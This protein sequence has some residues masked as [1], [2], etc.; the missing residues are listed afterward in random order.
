MRIAN[1]NVNSVRTRVTHMVQFLERQN[2]DVLLVQETKCKD[3]Q[4]PYDAFPD[5]EIAHV[6]YSQWNGVAILSRVGLDDVD[7]Q[8]PQQPGFH[9][10]PTQPQTVEARAV[11]ATC[12]GVRVWSVYV[13]N[14]R[15]IADPHYDY[16]L[17]WLRALSQHVQ[18][19]EGP[20]VIGGDFNIAPEDTHVWDRAAFTGLTHV[21]EPERQAFEHLLDAGL[22]VASPQD[23]YSYWDYKGYRI[24]RNEGMLIDF[25]LARDL[26]VVHSFIDVEE[27]H[28]V[29]PS[30][31]APVIV[32]YT[33]CT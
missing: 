2:I 10:D 33:P 9:K 5:Y 11:G 3:A 27:R 16:K 18:H 25:Q 17:R 31:H 6:G 15:A 19:T 4:F 1:W 12:G 22:T 21:S 26:S 23:G 20:M 29:Q 28:N 30:D 8:F 7:K 13:P 14:G 24:E 32:E